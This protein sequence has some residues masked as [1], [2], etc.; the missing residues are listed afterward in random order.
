MVWPGS[1]TLPW[2]PCAASCLTCGTRTLAKMQNPA[3]AWE[4][5]RVIR[6][7]KHLS[8]GVAVAWPCESTAPQRVC[9]RQM[10]LPILCS[11]RPRPLQN[12]AKELLWAETE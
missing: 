4:S 8:S 7:P 10:S 1:R 5:T 12:N 3:S 9:K 11:S 2:P 6:W